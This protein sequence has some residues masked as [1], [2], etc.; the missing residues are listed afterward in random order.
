MMTSHDTIS[1]YFCCH[2]YFFSFVT[3]SVFDFLC[4]FVLWFLRAHLA[5]TLCFL[6]TT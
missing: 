6:Y 4:F 3:Y 5:I 1:L 2:E